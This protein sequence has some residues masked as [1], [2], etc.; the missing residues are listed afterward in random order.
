MS[1]AEVKRRIERLEVPVAAAKL[2]VALY[3]EFNSVY[4]VAGQRLSKKQFEAWK[5][6]LSDDD[7]LLLVEIVCNAKGTDLCKGSCSHGKC[8][9]RQEADYRFRVFHGQKDDSCDEVA[10]D[11]I[12][13]E[14]S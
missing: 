14:K 10:A 4:E 8:A 13:E 6:T 2:H 7:E 11:K 12:A 5:A 9:A 1:K 3:E